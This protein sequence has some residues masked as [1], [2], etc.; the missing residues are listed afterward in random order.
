[1]NFGYLINEECCIEIAPSL[2]NFATSHERRKI[3]ITLYNSCIEQ[4]LKI[5][6]IKQSKNLHEMFLCKINELIE[7]KNF[8][9]CPISK[10]I[11]KS[12]LSQDFKSLKCVYSKLPIHPA[13]KLILM[14]YCHDGVIFNASMLFANFI[15][16]K[17]LKLHK[18]K[19]VIFENE[20]IVVKKD[21]CEILGIMPSFKYVKMSKPQEMDNEIARAFD[22][23][24]NRNIQ[25][26]FIAFPKNEEFTR[27]L[28]V[29]QYSEDEKAKLTLVPYAIT[30]Q[31]A[32]NFSHIQKINF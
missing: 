21:E 25:K 10:K 26:L 7:N 12:Y 23:L 22:I 20:L 24:Q 30:H 29:K 1:M 28:V 31:M 9:Y 2:F 14:I 32:C 19:E 15:Y 6:Y 27:H 8:S 11:I 4:N 3:F 16:D 18:D 13:A 17:M 5:N